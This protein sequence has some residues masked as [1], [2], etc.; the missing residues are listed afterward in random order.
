MTTALVTGATAGIGRAFATRLAGDGH[1]LVLVARGQERLDD[2][3]EQLRARCGVT[4]EVLVAD[5]SVRDQQDAVA[6]RLSD[7]AT[8]VDLLVNNAGFGVRSRFVGGQLDDE[9]RMLDVLVVAVLR[10]SHAAVPGMVERGHGAVVN[11]SSV[12][13]FVPFGTYAS[14]KAWVTFFSQGLA[15]E[16]AGTGVRAMALCPGFVH[17]EFHERAG[18][19]MSRLPDWLWLDADAVVDQALSDL[20]RGKVVSVPGR[21]YRAIAAGARL[22]PR[23][24]VRRASNRQRR[25]LR[26]F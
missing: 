8:P 14:A 9:Q 13:S 17:T 3:A 18:I 12:A 5:L 21:Q 15:S 4:V 6:Q 22:L 19:N 25:R 26:R 1:D 24:M 7:S 20:R 16:L 23:E 2:L 11:V 10:L